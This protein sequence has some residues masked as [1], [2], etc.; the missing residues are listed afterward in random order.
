MLHLDTL[1]SCLRFLG[2][3]IPSYCALFFLVTHI[4]N[5]F[6]RTAT[7]IS[8]CKWCWEQEILGMYISPGLPYPVN[9]WLGVRSQA[10]LLSEVYPPKLSK[11]HSWTFV[12]PLSYLTSTWLE[13]SFQDLFSEI[14]DLRSNLFHLLSSI[15]PIPPYCFFLAKV[16]AKLLGIYLLFTH[17]FF[18]PSAEEYVQYLP[19]PILRKTFLYTLLS[20]QQTFYF[21]LFFF[22]VQISVTVV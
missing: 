6:Q 18:H 17:I 13:F 14:L 2:T 12:W 9:N 1:W 15:L 20:S 10:S 22:I 8:F 7:R 5:I 16:T 3:L 4:G 19:G 11:V 21:L